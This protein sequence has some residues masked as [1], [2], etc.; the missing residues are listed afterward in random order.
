V[1]VDG[2]QTIVDQGGSYAVKEGFRPFV[3]D[4]RPWPRS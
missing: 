2:D 4:I 3:V 1:A